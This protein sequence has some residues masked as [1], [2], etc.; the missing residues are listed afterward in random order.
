MPANAFIGKTEQPT[1]GELSAALGPAKATWDQLLA[2]LAEEL[3]VNV[4]E[5]KCHSVKWGWSLRVKR[6]ARTIVWLSPS[7]DCFT[8]LFILG[9]KAM[10]AVRQTRFPQRIVKVLNDAP[11]YPEG[12]GVRLEVKS[13]KQLG[14]LMKLATIKLAN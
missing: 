1:D 5:W 10:S 4:H 14:P 7:A 13:V 12:T 3:G 11:K 2:D 8:V 6:K 9:S